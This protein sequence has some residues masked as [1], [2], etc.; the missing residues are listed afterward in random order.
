MFIS[1]LLIGRI[2]YTSSITIDWDACSVTRSTIPSV[3]VAADPEWLKGAK[4]HDTAIAGIKGLVKA[5]ADYIRLLNFN[6]FPTMS[7]AQL[8]QGKW[9]FEA[10]DAVMIDFMDAAGESSV[11][12]DIDTSPLWMW[13]D[14]SKKNNNTCANNVSSILPLGLQNRCPYYGNVS[15]PR[16]RTWKEIGE[17]FQRVSEWYTQGGFIDEHGVKHNGGHH[18]KFAYWEILNEPNINREH[19]FTPQ[20]IIDFYDMQVETMTKFLSKRPAK[21]FLS[22]SLAGMS[23]VAKVNTWLKPFLN[24][25]NHSPQNTTVDAISFHIYAQCDNNTAKGLERIFTT[26]DV[27]KEGIQ[28]IMKLKQ[29]LRPEVELHL[30]E[31]GILCNAP[32]SCINNNY[33][34]WYRTFGQIYWVASAGQWIYQFLTYAMEADLVSVAQSQILGYPY[35]YDGLSGEW[36]CG[37]MIDWD[38]ITLNPK[39]WAELLVLQRIGRPFDYCDSSDVPDDIYVQAIRSSKGRVVV[40]INKKST[41]RSIELSGA[42]GKNAF[43]IDVDTGNNPA[44]KLKLSSDVINL[45]S[46]ATMFVNW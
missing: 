33:T 2:L 42:K 41:R 43:V 4:M 5:G 31:S 45:K 24:S 20:G 28:R 39:Y 7:C 10:M 11:I 14:A 18:Y 27:R 9:N 38:D 29:M 30:T 26:T 1:F 8:E 21:K 15:I 12:I 37:S 13:E 36:P 40:L 19:G 46:F 25:S 6:I 17:Y 16:D 34:C 3:L 22:P 23:S 32:R 44:R 35:R